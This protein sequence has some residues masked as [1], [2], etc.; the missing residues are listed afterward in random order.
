[1]DDAFDDLWQLRRPIGS[2]GGFHPAVDVYRRE[3]PSALVVVVELAGVDS[4]DVEIAVA[5]G[6]LAVV[7]RRG[8]P[9]GG[10]RVMHLE[11]EHGEFRRQIQLPEDVDA[12]AATAEF[13]RGLLTIILPIVARVAAQRSVT[14]TMTNTP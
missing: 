6:Q 12:T 13:D 5:G 8:R 9:A 14:I 7:G 10:K 1:M 4:S 3:D 2:R 11:I